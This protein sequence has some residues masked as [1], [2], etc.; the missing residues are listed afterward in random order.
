MELWRIPVSGGSP[1][2][3]GLAKEGRFHDLRISPDGRRLAFTAEEPSKEVWVI[4][5]FLPKP[6]VSHR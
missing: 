6:E 3:V 2:R 4:E 1:E 5:N